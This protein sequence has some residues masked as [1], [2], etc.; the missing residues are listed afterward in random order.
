VKVLGKGGQGIVGL[1]EYI[2]GAEHV[3]GRRIVIK[4][5]LSQSLTAERD[6]MLALND[7][8]GNND[9]VVKLLY[10]TTPDAPKDSYISKLILEFCEGGDL[11]SLIHKHRKE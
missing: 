11:E 9:H 1:W 3:W 6:M 7:G 2:G 8:T 5:A 10:P 4:H